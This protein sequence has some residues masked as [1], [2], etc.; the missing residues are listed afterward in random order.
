MGLLLGLCKVW[1]ALELGLVLLLRRCRIEFWL[2]DRVLLVLFGCVFRGIILDVKTCFLM[3]KDNIRERKT[4][5]RER[6]VV[7]K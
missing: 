4:F 5:E 7:N 3:T 6:R 2:I 1:L